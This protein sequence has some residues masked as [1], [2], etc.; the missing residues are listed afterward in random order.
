MTPSALGPGIARGLGPEPPAQRAPTHADYPTLRVFDHLAVVGLCSAIPTP[1]FRAGGQLGAVQLGRLEALL[2]EL[3]DR[4][5]FRV[6]LIHHPVALSSEPT[7]RALWD[8][9][10]LRGVLARRGAELVLHG[11]KHR[12]RVNR[13]PGPKGEIPVIG[14]PSSSEV[15]SRPEKRAQYHLYTVEW[16]ETDRG[17]RL[18]AEVRGYDELSGAFQHVEEPLLQFPSG[19]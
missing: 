1:I 9:E 6:V 14:V 15:G 2:A 4:G 17:F 19:T 7:R 8:A 5:L 13:V 16:D 18:E 10:A 11:H 3:E 12:R